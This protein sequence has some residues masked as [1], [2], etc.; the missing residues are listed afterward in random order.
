MHCSSKKLI[1]NVISQALMKPQ[2]VTPPNP[3]IDS[4]AFGENHTTNSSYATNQTSSWPTTNFG[5]PQQPNN[6]M[7]NPQRPY[8]IPTSPHAYVNQQPPIRPLLTSINLLSNCFDV[9]LN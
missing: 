6:D 1:E 3:T 7:Y 2:D 4:R 5:M 8:E 9:K